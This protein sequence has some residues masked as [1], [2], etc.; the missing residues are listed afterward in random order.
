MFGRYFRG[1][2]SFGGSLLSE[3]YGVIQPRSQ[4]LYPVLGAPRPAHKP[5]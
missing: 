2:A 3:I 1:V 5:G 4:N